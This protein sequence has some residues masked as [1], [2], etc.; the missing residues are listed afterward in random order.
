S[1]HPTT[2]LSAAEI[3]AT[4]FFGEMRF[5]P[6]DPQNADNDRFVLSKGHAA[7]ILYAAWAEAGAFDRSEL[8]KLR[9]FE[10]DLEGHP[11]P[12]LPFVD[13]ATGSLG[14]GICA[15]VGIA[16]NARR[17]RS[18]H[19]TYVLLG[20]GESAEGSVWEA[21]QVAQH[22][23]LDNLCGITDVNGFGQSRAT[24]WGHDI[25]AFAIRWRA[26]GWHALVVNGHDTA[27]LLGAYAEAKRTAGRPT[28]ILA[29]TVKG[30]GVSVFA[31]KE[32]WHGK[33]LKKGE[34]TD[35]AVAEL[36]AQ[37]VE[38]GGRPAIP[39]PPAR[40]RDPIPPL[41]P[42][43]VAAP[44]YKP[45]DSVATREAYGTA[46]ATL[47]QVDPR[48]VAL[49]ADV[50]NSTFSDK[51]ERAHEDRFYQSF[52]AEQVMVGAA[53]G[54]ASRGA[55]PF[56][57]TFACF[58]TRAYDFIR[59]AGI[60]NLNVKL[61][62]SHAGVSIGED[63][64][65]QMALEDLAMMRAV[66]TCTVLYPCDAVSAQRLVFLAA[67]TPGLVYIRTSRPKTAVIYDGAE[68]FEVGG[69]KTL[70]S[71]GED[72]LTVVAAGVT[73]HE[74]LK[75]HQELA[76]DGL[77]IR[78]IDAYSVQP[79]DARTLVQSGRETNGL[80]V[81]VEDHYVHGGLGDAVSAVVSGERIA[82]H[83]LAVRE[84]LCDVGAPARTAD[85]ADNAGRRRRRQRGSRRR[86]QRPFSRDRAMTEMLERILSPR[87]VLA[88]RWSG[89]FLMVLATTLASA[90]AVAAQPARPASPE[91]RAEALRLAR[92]AKANA[93][94]PYKAGRIEKW[95][96]KIENDRFIEDLLTTTSGFHA[97]IGGITP[98]GGLGFGPGF[99]AK[100]LFD[101]RLD[102]STFAQIS[103][104]RYWIVQSTLEMPNLADGRAFARVFG[105]ARDFPQE[106]FFGLGPD[107]HRPDRTSFSY[108]DLTIGG[109]AGVRLRP[110]LSTGAGLDF[111]S[112]DIG[113]GTDKLFPSIEELFSDATVAGLATQ[114]AFLRSEGYID[115]DYATPVG[116]PRSGGHYRVAYNR[117]ADRDEGRY[118]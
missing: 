28:M 104:K 91:T 50:K 103:Y 31:G 6:N 73:V 11:T 98:G 61:G 52:I 90:H 96:T 97:K 47:G 80:I 84:T 32:G 41:D 71:S 94:R 93:V 63:G 78:V 113:R 57:S 18:D 107:S 48:V 111:I 117:Y 87:S 88:L 54:F 69:S 23:G 72:V 60:S 53:M 110:W 37:F 14:Q 76:A 20:D 79:I 58:L 81:T 82:V 112:P 106:D 118:S 8:L 67:A 115:V 100:G 27:A 102:F 46:L 59:M 51:F 10:S 39:P 21:A 55:I 7:P 16:L 66:P 34:E 92:A 116:N 38:D 15:A 12:R 43:S 105:R 95:L 36:D 29:K 3:M 19:R 26:F 114:P 70:R 33:P 109:A 74:A 25:E 24:Q 99:K 85:D 9:T 86:R 56:P 4:L 42:M 40:R 22:H 1:G 62:G 101:D 64:P 5:D 83:R 65:S 45:G 108:S 30:Q 75:A 35:R 44:A 17:I 49:D 13:V 89:G 2:C 68:R 77:P